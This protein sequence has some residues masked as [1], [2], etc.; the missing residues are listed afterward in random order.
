VNIL[1]KRGRIVQKNAQD[2]GLAKWL[3]FCER[4]YLKLLDRQP[5]NN[6]VVCE[7]QWQ[8]KRPGN[9]RGGIIEEER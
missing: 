3:Q 8:G 4:Q 6:K 2:S 9:P 7:C 5:H 1:S